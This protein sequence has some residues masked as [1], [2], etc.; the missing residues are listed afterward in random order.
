MITVKPKQSFISRKI[1]AKS[2]M[3]S[4]IVLSIST[5]QLNANELKPDTFGNF[6]D[7]ITNSLGQPQAAPKMF[8]P[9]SAEITETCIKSI[10]TTTADGKMY[11]ATPQKSNSLQWQ[12]GI[13]EEM[14]DWKLNGYEFDYGSDLFGLSVR[15]IPNDLK[16]I[17]HDGRQ[18]SYLNFGKLQVILYPYFNAIKK[19]SLITF[20]NE[21]NQL[22]CGTKAKPENCYAPPLFGSSLTWK[23][24]LYVEPLE[25]G[26]LWGRSIS[27]NFKV[28][29]RAS[30]KLPFD[31]VEISAKNLNYPDFVE[32]EIRNTDV[33]FRKKSDYVRDY[34]VLEL[35]YKSNNYTKYIANQ[36]VENVKDDNYIR[37]SSNAWSME[38]PRW[39]SASRSLE[40]KLKSPSYDHLGS[41]TVGYLELSIPQPLAKCLWN[42]EGK[43]LAKL[44]V[45]VFYDD[46]N[47][48]QVVTLSQTSNEK[49][50]NL[51]ANNFHY[52]SPIFAFKL[53]KSEGL[54]SQLT[55]TAAAKSKKTSISCVAGKKTKKVSGI[56]PKCPSGYKK[57]A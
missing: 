1:F 4:L 41:K 31:L 19:P 48:R 36:C 13:L 51:V 57:V 40:I 11:I 45:E 38:N 5:P 30:E 46:N 26:V 16:S 24:E 17:S 49:V 7:A 25:A 28:I 20:Q 33:I 42:V 44:D 12:Y 53:Q 56:K 23:M 14:P 55:R 52:S 3:I 6:P 18:T 15:Q 10:S 43:S 54:A 37:L 34:L 29:T 21:E 9:C 39:N 8:R 22:Q 35:N 50:I 32:S 47:E 2:M 27:S